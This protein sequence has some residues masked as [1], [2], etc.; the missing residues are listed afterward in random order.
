MSSSRGKQ[1]KSKRSTSSNSTSN[2]PTLWSEWEWEIDSAYWKRYRLDAAGN[3][4]F[5]YDPPQP[6]GESSAGGGRST[7]EDNSTTVESDSEP[8]ITPQLNTASLVRSGPPYQASENYTTAS[9]SSVDTITSGI[10]RLSATQTSAKFPQQSEPMLPTLPNHIRTRNPDTDREEFSPHY[11]VHQSW[12]F[13]YGRVFKV[14]WSE[15]KGAG[16][17][18]SNGG[19][20]N[21]SY[22]ERQDEN[23]VEQFQKVRRFIIISPMKGHCICLPINTYSKQGVTKNGV[24]AEHHTIVY[25]DKKPVYFHGEKDKGLTKKPLKIS[26]SPRHKL[27]ERSRLNYAK[28]YTVEYNVKVCF[29]GK[30]DKKS[31]WYLTADYNNTHPPIEH[32]TEQPVD[33]EAT[34][35]AEGGGASAYDY[36]QSGGGMWQGGVGSSSSAQVPLRYNPQSFS[37][38]S[39]AHYDIEEE[40]PDPQDSYDRYDEDRQP[41]E[42]LGDEGGSGERPAEDEA[43]DNGSH[44]DGGSRH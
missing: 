29:I 20:S 41:N 11:K 18:G 42:H 12:E 1:K 37:P 2:L 8:R 40:Q 35:Y 16:G 10:S 4:E 31:E 21:A 38:K 13:K 26:C 36:P 39:R 25:S 44:G 15:P 24:H 27:D 7:A 6:S 30:I 23:G 9:A 14:L 19:S 32:R 28:T 3:Y 34:E 33:D 22:T 43:A 17:L 5:E